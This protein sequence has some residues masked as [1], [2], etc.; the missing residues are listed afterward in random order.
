MQRLTCPQAP[1]R[2]SVWEGAFGSCADP[3]SG[4][5]RDLVLDLL[6]GGDACPGDPSLPQEAG[7]P[8]DQPSPVS[9][10]LS[11]PQCPLPLPFSCSGAAVRTRTGKWQQ[12]PLL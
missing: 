6:V 10:V 7:M 9:S 4:G 8:M 3:E 11:V 1:G 2:V 12:G 5:G